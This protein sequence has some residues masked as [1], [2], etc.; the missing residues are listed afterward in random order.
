[1]VEASAIVAVVLAAIAVV[2]T[3][4]LHVSTRMAQNK[5]R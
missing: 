1:M 3:V 4:A 5:D 2:V